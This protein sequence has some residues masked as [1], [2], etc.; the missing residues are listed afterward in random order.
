MKQSRL[1]VAALS[2]SCITTLSSC[3]K[4]EPLNAEC[5]IEQAFVAT[6]GQWENCFLNAT[7]TLKNVMSTDQ[8]ISFLVKRGTDLSHFAPKFNLTPGATLSPANGSEQDF[9]NGP[10]IYTVTS[11][12]G[13]WKRQ[14]KV[15]FTFPPIIY[16][17]MKYDFENYFLNENK[18]IHRYYVWSDK[19]DDGTLANNW[20]TGNPGFNFSKSSAK[21]DEYPTVP[22]EE[23]YDG[24][25]VKLTTSDTGSFGSMAKMPIAAGNLFIGKFDATQALKDAMKATQFGVP[26]SFKPTRFSG[27][28]KYKRGDVFTN[29]QKKVVEGKKDYGTIYA[30]FYDNHDEEGNSVVLYGDNVQTSPQVVALAIVPDI[31]DTPEWTHFDIDFI[32]KKEVDAQ[33][34]KNMGYSMAI[35]SSSSVEGASFMGAIGSTLWVD[36]FRITCEK[37]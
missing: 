8:E 14:Y 1:I 30:V 6:N 17:E 27:Y 22:V 32:Y 7:D 3:F 20:A 12:D 18:P 26:V 15:G 29:R 34:L 16:E 31:D 19:N 13:S 28:Y 9:T 2:M 11:E 36:K 4:E 25:C 5:D 10:V 24:A 21:P 23:G 33:K 37:E 35:V